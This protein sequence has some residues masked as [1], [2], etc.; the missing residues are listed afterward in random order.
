MRSLMRD[1]KDRQGHW[2]KPFEISISFRNT[3]TL[4]DNNEAGI[5][6]RE[7]AWSRIRSRRGDEISRTDFSLASSSRLREIKEKIRCSSKYGRLMRSSK[8]TNRNEQRVRRN[9]ITHSNITTR[10]LSTWPYGRI[11]DLACSSIESAG[12]AKKFICV[13]EGKGF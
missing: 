6:R 8:K 3:E 2:V 10:Y 5:S 1:L 11:H 13:C 9:P 12:E 4:S 7:K